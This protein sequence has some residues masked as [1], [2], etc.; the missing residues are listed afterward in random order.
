[1]THSPRPASATR[2]GSGPPS[3]RWPDGSAAPSAAALSGLFGRW[4]E[5][6]GEAIA[7]HARPTGLRDGRLVV[8]VDS[9]AWAA[10]LRY[11]GDELARRCCEVLGDDA[12]RRIEIRVGRIS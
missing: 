12:V 3:R 8:T 10:Q 4:E 2:T 7:A 1:M 11:M 6:V 5:I 9:T